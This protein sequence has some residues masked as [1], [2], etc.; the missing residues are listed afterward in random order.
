MQTRF[1][2]EDDAARA[3]IERRWFALDRAAGRLQQQCDGLRAAMQAAQDA[4]LRA[5][6][7]LAALQALRDAVG[8][9][10]AW[11]DAARPPLGPQPLRAVGSAG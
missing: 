10:L 7:E 11:R 4:W 1:D 9:E 8:D 6:S 3:L 5:Q 2:D